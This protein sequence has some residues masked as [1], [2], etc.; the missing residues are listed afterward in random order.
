MAAVGSSAAWA[1]GALKLLLEMG[2][3]DHATLDILSRWHLV[4]VECLEHGQD[5][6]SLAHSRDSLDLAILDVVSNELA[7]L[8]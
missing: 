1:S 7:L 2:W 8:D 3:R 6:A 5:I 4:L